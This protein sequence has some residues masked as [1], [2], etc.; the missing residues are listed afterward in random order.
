MAV[1]AST[2]VVV[3]RYTRKMLSNESTTVQVIS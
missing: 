1:V 2:T 3:I